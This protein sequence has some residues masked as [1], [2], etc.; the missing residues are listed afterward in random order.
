MDDLHSCKVLLA[1][2]PA[3]EEI[4]LK[5]IVRPVPLSCS[6]SAGQ[7]EVQRRR[8]GED[9][10]RRCR[11]RPQRG[12]GRRWGCA[13]HIIKRDQPPLR[14]T[15]KVDLD[16][17]R[18]SSPRYQNPHPP[19]LW[20]FPC[21]SLSGRTG[22]GWRGSS[23]SGVVDGD[24]GKGHDEGVG[25]WGACRII[26]HQQLI[27]SP[28]HSATARTHPLTPLPFPLPCSSPSP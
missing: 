11:R 26:Y 4:R 19:H 7:A 13:Q 17:H 20:P 22:V 16:T 18:R 28:P 2:P 3:E 12:G 27:P 8:R 1:E 24:G 5:A 15:P 23:G 14:Y 10:W 9:R 21:P 25:G 6:S